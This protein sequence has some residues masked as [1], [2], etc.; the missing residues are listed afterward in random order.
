MMIHG[1][2]VSLLDMVAS[3]SEALDLI[4]PVVANHHKQ[5]AYIA[6][7]IAQELNLPTQE[8]MEIAL[9]AGL[10]DIGALSLQERL[11]TL[12][13]EDHHVQKHAEIGYLFL[14]EFAPLANVAMLIRYHHKPWNKGSGLLDRGV[15]VPY[16]SHIIHLADRIA[17]LIKKDIDILS[18]S[19]D[20]VKTIRSY[21]GTMFNPEQV[22]AFIH[23]ANY[24]YFW[25][26]IVSPSLNVVITR[27]LEN[28]SMEMDVKEMDMIAQFFARM[29]DLRSPLNAHHSR[30]VA[31]TAEYIAKQAGFSQLECQM[32]RIAGYLHDLGKL[33]IPPSILE[34]PGSLTKVEYDIIKSH[35]YYTYRILGNI[36]QADI[37]NVWAALH[38][39]RLDGSGYPFHMKERALPLG[40]QIMAVADILT[41]ICEV[42]PYRQGMD[43]ESALKVMDGHVKDKKINGDLVGILHKNFDEID[44]LRSR[45]QSKNGLVNERIEDMLA[46]TKDRV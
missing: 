16:G 19:A 34:K 46:A 22:E 40:S 23:L 30:G 17:V 24:E 12:K 39:E 7:S 44:N 29:I 31:I 38:H 13:F 9:A 42:R 32:M 21:S 1:P 27:R 37:I 45:V 33:A 18:Q 35:A 2:R 5:V 11:D 25:L 3:F 6:F 41:A 28:Q 36:R 26:D 10:H 4:S 8:T 15:A 20:I 14:R 43:R